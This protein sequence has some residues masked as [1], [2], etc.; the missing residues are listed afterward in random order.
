MALL[1]QKVALHC[2]A[3]GNDRNIV[4]F[5]GSISTVA[6]EGSPIDG[7]SASQPKALVTSQGYHALIAAKLSVA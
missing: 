5:T 3:W 7:L 4:T 1:Q 2:Y 6:M